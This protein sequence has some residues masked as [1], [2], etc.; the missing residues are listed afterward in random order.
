MRWPRS[1]PDRVRHP[2]RAAAVVV[3]ALLAAGTAGTVARPAAADPLGDARARAAALA[4]GLQQLRVQAE[5]ATEA[6]DAAQA[7]L[8]EL[9]GQRVAAERRL[10]AARAT[11]VASRESAGSRAR[12]LYT[13]GGSAGLLSTVLDASDMHDLASRMLTVRRLVAKDS[14]S[15]A[16][17]EAD[18]AEAA[19]TADDVR[20]LTRRQAALEQTASEQARRVT[21][22]IAEQDR[23]LAAA[24]A[25]VTRLADEQ[26]QQQMAAAALRFQVALGQARGVSAEATGLLATQPEGDPSVV[27][28]TALAAARALIGTPYVWGGTG[29]QGY[30]CSGLTGAA[31]AAAGIRLPRTA[32][33]Q[34]LAGPHPALADL[35]PG[36]LLFWA[37]DPNDMST[38]HHVAIYAGHGMMVSTN[39]TGDVAREQPVWYDEFVGATRPDPAM[40]AAVP[41]PRWVAG[42]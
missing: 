26:A 1:V 4:T 27:G 40:A 36:D 2:A 37:T 13:T 8:A 35:R 32:A 31:Y 3:L 29:P 42:R 11:Q 22:A 17:A 30:D 5:Q 34:Y 23:M 16:Q 19:R 28:A 9:T 15:A 20:D 41:G 12:A 7:E 39:H 21:A 25:D 33:Q 18:A 6:Y 24:D 38:I 14:A 10:D